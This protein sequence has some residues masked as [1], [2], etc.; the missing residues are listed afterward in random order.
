MHADVP[1]SSGLD[2]QPFAHRSPE[3]VLVVADLLH[4]GRAV[5]LVVRLSRQVHFNADDSTGDPEAFP[6][7][8]TGS[9]EC[10]MCNFRELCDR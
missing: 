1:R 5:I 8:E 7:V 3:R 2:L 6:M 10:S 4:V 9:R